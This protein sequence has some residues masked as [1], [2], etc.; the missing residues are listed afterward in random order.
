MSVKILPNCTTA[1]QQQVVQPTYNKLIEVMKA[2]N[3]LCASSDDAS[4]VVDL[5]RGVVV[6]FDLGD[7]FRDLGPSNGGACAPAHGV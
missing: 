1:A 3:K 6:N 5:V 7:G 2:C 4:A